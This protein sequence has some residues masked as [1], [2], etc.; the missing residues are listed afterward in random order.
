MKGWEAD[1]KTRAKEVKGDDSA[2]REP[3]GNNFEC[4]DLVV[5]LGAMRLTVRAT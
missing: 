1:G 4:G 5:I 3:V 2:R